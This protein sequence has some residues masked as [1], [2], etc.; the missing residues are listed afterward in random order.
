M[1]LAESCHKLRIKRVASIYASG[2]YV[3]AESK[4]GKGRNNCGLEIRLAVLQVDYNQYSPTAQTPH[5]QYLPML[6][7][8]LFCIHPLQY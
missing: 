3:T 8:F 4:A 7:A 2:D 6:L 5:S 1:Q